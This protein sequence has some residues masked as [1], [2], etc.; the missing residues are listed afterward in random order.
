MTKYAGLKGQKYG[1]NKT[2]CCLDLWKYIIRP[3]SDNPI[4]CSKSGAATGGVL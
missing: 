2:V 1:N 3:V 4:T